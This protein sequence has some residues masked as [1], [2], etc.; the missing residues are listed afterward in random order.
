M[1][2]FGEGNNK[3]Q[4]KRGEYYPP[5]HVKFI[6]NKLVIDDLFK[7]EKSE[8]CGLQIGDVI[9][10][11]NGDSVEDLVK[12][13]HDVYPASNQP[14][15]LRDISFNI[16]RSTK[17][18]LDLDILRD[19]KSKK[20]TLNLY[21]R[22]DIEGFYSWYIREDDGS[23]YK[24]LDNNIGYITL[25]NIKQ[26]DVDDIK[27]AFKDTKG[28]IIDI[29]NYPSAFMP[30]SLGSFLTSKN[31]E[32]VKFTN[33]NVD[34]PGEF[35]FGKTLSIPSRG[36]TYKGKVVVLIN[37]ISQS[38]AE[39]TTMAFRAG[40]NVTVV[41]STTAGADGNVSAIFLPG[42][43]RTMISGIGVYY[44]DGTETQRV[45]IVPDIEV[46]PTIAGIKQGRDE[47]M[48]K[49]V[50]LITKDIQKTQTIKD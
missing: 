12:E 27:K 36:K 18:T 11:I 40:D 25:K 20:I 14:T 47:L 2:I 43:L 46:K 48:D 33:G 34:Y 6:E 15:R 39:Y 38:Q 3:I 30:F 44:P 13:K 37:E 32:F 45:G 21:E 24:M 42:G 1:L 23:S 8:A 31:T 35:T 26:E 22:K 41:G 16:L 4:E 17:N 28:I 5:V 50:E 10:N 9:T 7:D 29:R 19:G 49:A